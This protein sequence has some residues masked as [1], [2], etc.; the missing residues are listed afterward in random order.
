MSRLKA[1]S[2]IE[3][4]VVIGLIC[5]LMQLLRPSYEGLVKKTRY[6]E[7][8]QAL[9]PVK[10]SVVMCYMQKG[11]LRPCQSGQS[12]IEPVVHDHVVDLI[13]KIE[14]LS[15]GVIHVV[16]KILYGFKRADDLLLTPSVYLGGVRWKLTGGAVE[17]GYVQA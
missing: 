13:A 6:T 7:I 10:L 17:R 14:V 2:L 12:G 11:S 15:G 8:L 4:M 3:M 16:P 1:Y 9:G 5:L